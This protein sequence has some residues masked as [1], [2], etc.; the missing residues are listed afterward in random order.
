MTL[1]YAS[2]E[3][4]VVLF[5]RQNFLQKVQTSPNFLIQHLI[6]PPK[7][8]GSTS[9]VLWILDLSNVLKTNYDKMFHHVYFMHSFKFKTNKGT[10][11]LTLEKCQDNITGLIKSDDDTENLIKSIVDSNKNLIFPVCSKQCYKYLSSCKGK[12]DI[13]SSNSATWECD[14]SENVKCSS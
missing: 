14:G 9:T 8:M 4:E 2:S 3:K 6:L 11:L 13:I 5:I 10:E 1:P 7:I 12:K